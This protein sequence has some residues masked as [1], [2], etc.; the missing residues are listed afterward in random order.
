MTPVKHCN[1]NC[2]GRICHSIFD[3]N[4]TVDTNMSTILECIY[5]LLLNPDVTDPLDRYGRALIVFLLCSIDRVSSL[6][7][8]M[9][10]PS[11]LIMSDTPGFATLSTLVHSTLALEF[12]DDSG[13][14]EYS[15]LEHVKKYA[16]KKRNQW[17]AELENADDVPA[18]AFGS[19]PAGAA[20]KPAGAAAGAPAG[21][22]ASL[23]TN[24]QKS[25][26][27]S[28]CGACFKV[29]R[30][31]G[32]GYLA[33]HLGSDLSCARLSGAILQRGMPEGASA[34]AS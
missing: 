31:C 29:P 24:C 15:I 17:R 3:R 4:Y 10:R 8:A 33:C 30:L 21:A 27:V 18:G 9:W 1:I 28:L 32:P 7:L 6:A 23:C 12:Y 2:Y 20:A 14:Y 13:K 26:P 25:G 22:V 11:V 16:T 5:G 19:E 34:Q